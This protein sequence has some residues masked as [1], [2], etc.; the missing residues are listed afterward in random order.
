MQNISS[1][2]F[3]LLLCIRCSYFLLLSQDVLQLLKSWIPSLKR[4]SYFLL[5]S[6]DVLQL[7]KYWWPSLKS[8]LSQDPL[9]YEPRKYLLTNQTYC[10]RNL[11]WSSTRA[12]FH[13]HLHLLLQTTTLLSSTFTPFYLQLLK[14]RRQTSKLRQE[15]QPRCS[16]SITIINGVTSCYLIFSNTI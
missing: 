15:A 13:Y 8:S 1:T 4:C 9:G 14:F 3:L 2:L 6:H 12:L 11:L 7:L 5:L 16:N 10:R